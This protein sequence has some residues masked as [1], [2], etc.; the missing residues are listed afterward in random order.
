MYALV[1]CRSF[2]VSCERVFRPDLW[3]KPVVVLSNNDGCI[4]ARS[5]EAK[6][7]GLRMGE[8]VF[9]C[10]H[11]LKQNEVHVFSANFGLYGDLSARIMSVL[12]GFSPDIEIYSIDEAFL[13]FPND[14]RDYEVLGRHICERV[15]RWVGVPVG[16]GFGHSKTLAKA[17]HEISK[18][19]SGVCDIHQ[20]GVTHTLQSL[21]VADIWGIGKRHS[22]FLNSNGIYTAR[23]F[24]DM[25]PEV[26]R[27]RMHTPG[28][29]T[30]QELKG[31]SCIPLE[32][33][34][35]ER[36]QI[37][38]SRSF[39]TKL[40]EQ[41]DVRGA[42][43]DNVA[44]ASEKLRFYG[45][46]AQALMVFIATSRYNDDYY[47]RSVVIP[48]PEATASSRILTHYSGIGLEYVYKPGKRYAKSGV[49]LMNLVKADHIQGNLFYKGACQD[50]ALMKAV[51][52]ING[53]WGRHTLQL[54]VTQW[55]NRIWKMNQ[56]MKSKRFTTS[57]N[58][59]P[60]VM[61]PCVA[62]LYK[63]KTTQTESNGSFPTSK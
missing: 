28:F 26:V 10:Q 19:G 31:L 37:V 50:T 62:D 51:D 20:R 23:Q 6:A 63:K 30:Q 55:H 12:E 33:V 34:A 13:V 52:A 53:R 15:L 44:V 2:Y 29:R 16:V 9:K 61:S 36:K 21:P 18:K 57:W 42:L 11:I 39:G 1:D 49:M 47:S 5:Q 7:L 46:A 35:E 38:S 32:A 4:I 3:G 41:S 59:L 43:A 54:A 24:R 8:A 56:N 22:A 14:N 48:L 17:A 27:K 40:T 58:E 25:P 60:E 45:Q